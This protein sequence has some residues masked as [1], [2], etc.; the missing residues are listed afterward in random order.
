[1]L[2]DLTFGI[3]W[4]LLLALRVEAQPAFPTYE[5][6]SELLPATP[7]SYQW[8]M[9]SFFNPAVLGT[10]D[11][12][13]IALHWTDGGG[14]WN[15]F[16]RWG[17]VASFP[18]MSF[19]VV[20]DKTLAITTTD[21]RF[22]LAGGSRSGGMGISLGF[23]DTEPDSLDRPVHLVLGT[24]SRPNRYL[25]IGLTGALSLGG[26]TREAVVDV[27]V[28]P[29]GNQLVTLFGDYVID[30]R[31]RWFDGVW[32]AGGVVEPVDG[33]RLFGRYF[34][35]GRDRFSFGAALSLGGIGASSH[36]ALSST[37]GTLDH[38]S[39]AYA[40]R[41][42]RYDR[43]LL[44]SFGTRRHYLSL[45]L[46]GGMSYQRFQLFDDSRTLRE[47]LEQ[48]DAARVDPIIAGV[49]INASD[50]AIDREKLWELRQGLQQLRAAGK[51]VVVFFERAD[52]DAYHL[53]S[54]AD[55]VVMDP[56]GT[57]VLEGYASGRT[58][59][60]RMLDELGVGFEEIRLFR[61]KSA[62]ENFA[63]QQMSDPERE[64]RQRMVD[65]IYETVRA[66]V[67]ASGR[68]V[69]T[70]A[71]DRLIDS[72][73]L[74]GAD[75]A[76]RLGLVDA[77]GRWRDIDETASSLRPGS[78]NAV[79]PGRL[80]R[81]QL[82]NDDRWG[83]PRRIG[84]VYALGATSLND[85]IR[86]R[87]LARRIDQLAEDS[88]VAAIVVRV[89][90]PGGD[91]LAADLV[92]EAMLRARESKPV[93]VSH[94]YVAASGGYWIS[95]YG[96]AIVTAPVSITGSI[97][98]ISAWVYDDG[99]FDS[100]GA[101]HDYVQRGRHADLY[102]G[103]ELPLIGLGLPHRNLRADERERI[104]RHIRE[105][106]TTFVAKVAAGR[107]MSEDQVEELAQ[108]RVWMGADAVANGLAD[109]LGG[110]DVAIALAR[111]RAGV[112]PDEEMA[113]VEYPAP[114]LFD[115]SILGLGL[116]RLS[117]EHRRMGQ[118][119]RL[120]IEHNGRALPLLPA[121]MDVP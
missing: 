8:G 40:L 59:Y 90:S 87:Q 99:A 100:L 63:R 22:S 68:A 54:V 82:P 17:L 91:A 115:P 27:G 56:L 5:S 4:L 57:L 118:M 34:G 96:D 19:G 13:E 81:Y 75:E 18:G 70:D 38:A 21:Y 50:M 80:S 86:G 62:F 41:I 74:L 116:P 121:D 12:P 117:E 3:L 102:I 73:V 15:A 64:Q 55:R 97:G 1:M 10:L 61:Y 47:T 65:V 119:L 26:A 30:R 39:T 49:V 88:D 58:Y 109:R 2:R 44:R 46:G 112:A 69:D 7:S 71:F 32:S 33:V 60:A 77:V 6:T 45:D 92:A 93:I 16:T 114:S 76:L 67:V 95:M 35:S 94:G 120:L 52:L 42:G 108:G 29:F 51:Y 107:G 14:P 79:G 24:L 48:L 105:S 101:D 89:D 78:G 83:E 104:E 103:P 43:T 37:A 28:R 72:V 84:V 111:E 20:R 9:G 85:G 66:D 106:Y 110:L 36:A 11:G 113:V 25:S 53:I 31:D 98:V 23:S